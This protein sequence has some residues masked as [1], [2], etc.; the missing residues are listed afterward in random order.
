MPTA[1]RDA[2][3]FLRTGFWPGKSVCLL[4]IAG[5][6]YNVTFISYGL[7]QRGT[8]DERLVV[9][10]F[11]PPPSPPRPMQLALFITSGAIRLSWLDLDAGNASTIVGLSHGLTPQW[12]GV[13]Y[14][15][16]DLSM[17]V[18]CKDNSNCSIED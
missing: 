8:A 12:E 7:L 15:G 4:C 17:A 9:S 18:G 10:F 16:L 2:Q 6:S 13:S 5:A 14:D 3:K 1:W 11:Q